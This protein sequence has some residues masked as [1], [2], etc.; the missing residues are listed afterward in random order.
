M[1]RSL[2]LPRSPARSMTR[3][4]LLQRPTLALA[5]AATCTTVALSTA[6][7]QGTTM[8]RELERLLDTPPFHRNHWGMVVMEMDGR[9]VTS[10]HA[11]QLFM[12]AS[13]TKLLV[14]AAAAVLL[15]PG[16]TVT[17]SLYG[18]GPVVDGVVQGDL[19]LYGRGD[20]TLSKRCYAVDTTLVGV[21]QADA[22]EPLRRLARQLRDAGVT[23]I[24][25]DL[26]GDGSWFE[27][28]LVHPTWEVYDLNWWY[29]APVSALGILDNAVSVVHAGGLAIGAPA[30][31]RI[32]PAI[33]GVVLENRTRTVADSEPQT[34]DYFRTEG[35][36][37]IVA[38][39]TVRRSTR[40]TTQYFALPD[41]N[42]MTAAVFRRILAEEGV[43]VS[44][45]T[46]STADSLANRAHRQSPALAEIISR[47]V[48]DWIFP[49]QNSSQNWF[50]EMLLKQL[51]RQF[52]GEGSWRAGRDVVRRFLVDSVGID[53][54]QF[55]QVDG[56]GLSAQNL[57]S[58]MVLARLLRWMHT[59][60][61]YE[62]FAA[63]LPRSG[64]RGSL[65]TR[66]VGTP[67]EGRVVAKTGTI[68]SVNALSGY[69]ERPGQLPLI[70]SLQ[71]NHHTLPS[72]VVVRQLDSVVVRMGRP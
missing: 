52:R 23:T 47:P 65:R 54:T 38:E 44:G 40:P 20:P 13:N 18:G 69:I 11:E 16:F 6:H 25:G 71:A 28:L 15:P 67:L 37:T 55:R 29:A 63:G 10:R 68:A 58:P 27:P 43:A 64:Q 60:P 45:A 56:S 41:P 1:R 46:R 48:E 61:R 8:A 21:C 7:A 14:A 24:A 19:V 12:P 2:T 39:G 32:E 57:V 4:S 36:L 33:D 42:L 72:L 51:G 70:F 35:T 31:I 26:I 49:V 5:L 66:F 34:L 53:S 3:R 22:T 62:A 17:T 30:Q 9:V 50:A 59:H